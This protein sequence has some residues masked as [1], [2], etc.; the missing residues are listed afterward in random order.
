LIY[1]AISSL[2]GYVADTEGNFEWSV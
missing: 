1:G 2:D